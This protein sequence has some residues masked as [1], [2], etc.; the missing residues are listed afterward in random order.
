MS[1]HAPTPLLKSSPKRGCDTDTSS[2]VQ[3]RLALGRSRGKIHSPVQDGRGRPS[4]HRTR[5]LFKPGRKV[6]NNGDGLADLLRN[7][8]EKDFLA[9]WRDIVEDLRSGPIADEILRGAEL[10]GTAG[11]LYRHREKIVSRVHIVERFAV[12]APPRLQSSPGRDLPLALPA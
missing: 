1:V 2:P 11:V 8:V 4:L 10:Q 6:C 9:V 3:S 7:P 5:L 12:L